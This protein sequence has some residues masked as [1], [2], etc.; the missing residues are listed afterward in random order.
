MFFLNISF[1]M[2]YEFR[3]AKAENNNNLFSIL[4]LGI[5]LDILKC[6]NDLQL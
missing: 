2:K 6:R 5:P 3:N 4:V 1:D